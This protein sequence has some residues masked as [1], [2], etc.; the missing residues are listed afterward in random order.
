M[1]TTLLFL[2]IL[3]I[4]SSGI[5]QISAAEYEAGTQ[6]ALPEGALARLGKGNAKMATFSPDGGLL[7][8]AGS[9]GVW[10]YDVQSYKEV[11]LLTGHT[12]HV[13]CVA[14]SPDGKILASGST[15]GT[16]LLFSPVWKE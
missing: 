11:S 10:L 8:V 6:I 9:I 13:A 4:I 2:L 3:L 12:R 15:D 5:P 7:A 16:I 14:F 1:K